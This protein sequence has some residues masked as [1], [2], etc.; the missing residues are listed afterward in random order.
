[1]EMIRMP[2][3]IK[4]RMLETTYLSVWRTLLEDQHNRKNRSCSTNFDS[5]SI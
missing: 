1:M 3:H 5:I 4:D 2:L